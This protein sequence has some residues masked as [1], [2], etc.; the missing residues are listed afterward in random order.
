MP[1]DIPKKRKHRHQDM[2][3]LAR[4][5]FEFQHRTTG[6]IPGDFLMTTHV[7]QFT[8]TPHQHGDQPRQSGKLDLV[9]R[10]AKS[11]TMQSLMIDEELDEGELADTEDAHGGLGLSHD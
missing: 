4:T 9:E 8:K 2:R 7:A 5:A 10:S 1:V 6:M 3:N 11:W